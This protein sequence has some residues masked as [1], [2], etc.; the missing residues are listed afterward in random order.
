MISTYLECVPKYLDSKII[1]IE[2]RETKNRDESDETQSEYYDSESK[3]SRRQKAHSRIVWPLD[4][5]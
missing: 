3:R 1:G 2:K 5:S 4:V